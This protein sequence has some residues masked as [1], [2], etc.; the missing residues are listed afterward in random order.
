M[1]ISSIFTRPFFFSFL[2]FTPSFVRC[3][4]A[5]NS[6]HQAKMTWPMFVGVYAMLRKQSLVLDGV[7]SKPGSARHL[8]V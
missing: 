3:L 5:L 1:Q 2:I 6:E 4:D 7:G 8:V